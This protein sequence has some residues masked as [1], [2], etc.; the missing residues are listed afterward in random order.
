MSILTRSPRRFGARLKA[1]FAALTL[2]TACGLCSAAP[3][4]A[5]DLL[6][7][8]LSDKGVAAPAATAS[9]IL[10]GAATSA[11]SAATTTTLPADADSGDASLAQRVREKASEMVVSAMNFLGVPY[12][13]GGTDETTGFDCSGFT[14]HVFELSAGL[15]LPR[16][17]DQQATTAGLMSVKRDDLMP[18]DLVFFNTLRRTFSHVGIYLGDG[19]FIHAPRSGSE[20]RV[21]DMGTAY[22][23]RRFTGARRADLAATPDSSPAVG[24]RMLS[25]VTPTDAPVS[26]ALPSLPDSSAVSQAMTAVESKPTRSVKS[27]AR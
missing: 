18:G 8:L 3:G 9:A 2:V 21:E 23:A 22:W 5:T 14:R 26:P 13:R 15:L 27:P 20:V 24:A 17:A 16:R 12:R 6:T 11:S 10:S 7:R 1:P 19:K 4:D 25:S